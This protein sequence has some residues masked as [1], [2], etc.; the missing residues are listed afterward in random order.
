MYPLLVALLL[1]CFYVFLSNLS[2]FR[3]LSKTKHKMHMQH[4]MRS[5]GVYIIGRF[6]RVGR[7][8]SSLSNRTH[9]LLFIIICLSKNVHKTQRNTHT[10]V[11]L[12]LIGG[13]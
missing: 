7:W 9:V 12:F 10:T 3:I 2:S 6:A 13:V 8:H 4:T 11:V 1:V 5:N